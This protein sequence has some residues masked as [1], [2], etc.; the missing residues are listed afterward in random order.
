MEC[1]RVFAP[2]RNVSETAEEE[3]PTVWFTSTSQPTVF[4]YS[5]G[6]TDNFPSERSMQVT[7]CDRLEL[8]NIR[9]RLAERG[10]QEFSALINVFEL[11]KKK[12]NHLVNPTGSSE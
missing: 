4:K 5:T 2:Q 11:V 12:H 7:G 8:V 1:H 3:K 9:I 10:K 6:M